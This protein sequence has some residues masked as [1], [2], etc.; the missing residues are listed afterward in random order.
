MIKRY[1]VLTGGEV[2]PQE[3]EINVDTVYKRYN[4][5]SYVDS[6]GKQGYEYDMDEMTL[7]EYFRNSIP[8]NQV[9]TEETLGELSILLGQYQEE[10]DKTLGEL[11]ILLAEASQNV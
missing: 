5:H 6:E 11:S 9:L 4:I 8:E 1:G 10:I 2:Y 3:L 7:V